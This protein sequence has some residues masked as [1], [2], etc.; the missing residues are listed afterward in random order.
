LLTFLASAFPIFQFSCGFG[1]LGPG[2]PTFVWSFCSPGYH[3]CVSWYLFLDSLKLFVQLLSIQTS[4]SQ[5]RE[6]S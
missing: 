3:W 4:T 5:G 2:A 1:F 6:F